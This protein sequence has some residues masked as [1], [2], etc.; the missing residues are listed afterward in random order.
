MAKIVGGQYVSDFKEKLRVTKELERAFGSKVRIQYE[1][2][3]IHYEAY[4]DDSLAR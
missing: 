4:T 2:K 3:F 1:D